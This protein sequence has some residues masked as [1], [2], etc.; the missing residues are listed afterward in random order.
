MKNSNAETMQ[1]TSLSKFHFLG[2]IIAIEK[3]LSCQKS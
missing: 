3:D 2:K 1:L